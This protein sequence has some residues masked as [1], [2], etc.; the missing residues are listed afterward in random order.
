MEHV[1]LRRSGGEV[2]GYT[3]TARGLKP[4]EAL[5]ELLQAANPRSHIVPGSRATSANLDALGAL[6]GV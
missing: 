2:M 6:A 5:N 3:S 1:T 4:G